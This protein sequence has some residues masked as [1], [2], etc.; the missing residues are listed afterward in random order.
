M[1]VTNTQTRRA[2]YIDG[3]IGRTGLVD[4]RLVSRRLGLANPETAFFSRIEDRAGRR[5][6]DILLIGGVAVDSEACEYMGWSGS[7]GTPETCA[8]LA[9]RSRL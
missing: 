4:Q 1:I 6:P 2:S 9:E 5:G 7:H 3:T 8:G